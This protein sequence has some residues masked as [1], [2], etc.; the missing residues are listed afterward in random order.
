VATLGSGLGAEEELIIQPFD[1]DVLK[2]AVDER[3]VSV[4]LERSTE[5]RQAQQV[6]EARPF[7]VSG[8]IRHLENHGDKPGS[9]SLSTTHGLFKVPSVEPSLL[10]RAGGIIR[11]APLAIVALAGQGVFDGKGRLQ[12]LTHLTDMQ[13]IDRPFNPD[14][15]LAELRELSQSVGARLANSRPAIQRAVLA[16]GRAPGLFLDEDDDLEARWLIR[17]GDEDRP[18][19]VVSATF[20]SEITVYVYDR[21][22]GEVTQDATIDLDGI[23]PGDQIAAIIGL[24][25]S[26]ANV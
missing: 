11:D 8:T 21:T 16:T 24:A 26:D 25:E 14:R 15:R 13:V 9:L 18:S 6:T 23:T 7:F 5:T 3:A 17:R 12:S 4:T 22:A 10:S 19:I 1:P 2:D 20:G